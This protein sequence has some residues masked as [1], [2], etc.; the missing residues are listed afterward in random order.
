M[1]SEHGFGEWFDFR[2]CD[3]L[4]PEL[5]PCD[6][7]GFDSAEQADVA[8][9]AHASPPMRA[10][11]RSRLSL[12]GFPLL[13]ASCV[14]HPDEWMGLSGWHWSRTDAVLGFLNAPLTVGTRLERVHGRWRGRRRVKNRQADLEGFAGTGVPAFLER[15]K[16]IGIRGRANRRPAECADMVNV[17]AH[18]TSLIGL[19]R[20]TVGWREVL[21]AWREPHDQP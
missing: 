7:G 15:E 19:S 13:V 9:R 3:W 20:W 4:P 21:V 10:L 12:I 16:R 1:L 8:Y 14:P 2:V 17:Y 6:G 5:V 18:E 11:M